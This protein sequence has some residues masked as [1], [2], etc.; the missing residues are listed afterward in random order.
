VAGAK[1]RRKALSKLSV[2]AGSKSRRLLMVI[3]AWK[4]W[5]KIGRQP[6]SCQPVT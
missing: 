1:N 2:N 3:L 4:R 6:G 5:M